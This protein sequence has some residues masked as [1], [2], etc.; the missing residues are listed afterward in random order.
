MTPRFIRFRKEILSINGIKYIWLD[1][2]STKIGYDTGCAL[3]F[4]GDVRDELWEL[5]KLAMRQQE[6]DVKTDKCLYEEADTWKKATVLYT[7]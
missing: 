4:D 6:P 3:N 7:A 1:G 5:I 2:E